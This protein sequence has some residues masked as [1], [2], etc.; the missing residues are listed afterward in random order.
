MTNVIAGS[1]L[2]A[3]SFRRN[4]NVDNDVAPVIVDVP[5]DVRLLL[6]KLRQMLTSDDGRSL[7]YLLEITRREGIGL[8]SLD[9]QEQSLASSAAGVDSIA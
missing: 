6:M 9:R 7:D 3:E 1:A 4:L 5:S 2:V 8:L